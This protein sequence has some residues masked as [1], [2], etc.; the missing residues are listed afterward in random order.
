MQG[1]GFTGASEDLN[2]DL[3]GS[4]GILTQ[5]RIT[6]GQAS[7]PGGFSTMLNT[8]VSSDIIKTPHLMWKPT[9]NKARLFIVLS[10]LRV[11]SSCQIPRYHVCHT[12]VSVET[13]SHA[14]FTDFT[15]T[16]I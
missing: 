15:K 12:V 11:A 9:P 2:F 13:Y 5:N 3:L 4:L 16:M 7:Q 10:K 8:P 6:P 14:R 1:G